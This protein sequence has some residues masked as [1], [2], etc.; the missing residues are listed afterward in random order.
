MLKSK[1]WLFQNKDKY[2]LES[3]DKIRYFLETGAVGD[4]G[5]LKVDRS[6]ALN[7]VWAKNH[8]KI[9]RNIHFLKLDK[10]RPL[11][12]ALALYFPKSLALAGAIGKIK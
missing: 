6:R 11:N 8:N 1:I 4:D 3:G 9:P 2:F 5:K 12:T 10:K 7:K